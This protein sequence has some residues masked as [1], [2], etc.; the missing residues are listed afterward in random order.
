MK[1]FKFGGA[2]VR[3]AEGVRNLVS[4]VGREK[5]PLLVIVSAMGKTTNAMERVTEHFMSGNREQAAAAMQERRGYHT[6]ITDGLFGRGAEPE[7][8]T[9][10]WEEL[11][12]II[13][14]PAPEAAAYDKWYDTVVGYGE[15]LSTAIISEYMTCEGIANRLLDMRRCFVT[16][17]RHRDAD[18]DLEASVPLMKKCMEASDTGLFIGQGFIG[19]GRDGSCVTL[20]R[21]GSDYSAAAA[22]YILDAESVTI[23]KDVD[24]ILNADPKLFPD[25]TLIPELTYL[26]AVELAYSGAQIIHPKT[27]KPLQNKGI[28]LY[29][30]PFGDASKPG[31]VIKQQTRRRIGVPVLIL[32]RNQV[33]ISIRPNDFSFVLEERLG[34]IFSLLEQYG[35]KPNLIQSSAVNLSICVDRTR[36][37]PE[38]KK[39]LGKQG[40]RV[41]YNDDMRLLTI[42]GYTPALY[43][44]YAGGK[45]VFLVQKTRRT[46]RVVSRDV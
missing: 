14:G 9:G 39:L 26:D 41:V 2:S 34:S 17:G 16:D 7:S 44:K 6:G 8:V 15:L 28:P 40:Y 21:E 32:K 24:G 37:L 23:W 22:A 42:R 45:D 30:R 25:T 5:H 1:V 36:R 11:A 43:E 13:A 10:L 35:I 4:I 31:S 29:V 27:I 19:G 33:L 46:M 38:V 12:T 3:S 18:I 20:G